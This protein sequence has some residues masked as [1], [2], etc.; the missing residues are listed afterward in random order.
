VIWKKNA[1]DVWSFD[2]VD[3]RNCFFRTIKGDGLDKGKTRLLFELVVYVR[4]RNND[5]VT[6]MC[7]GWCELP[8]ADL[9]NSM[10]HKLEIQGGSPK[11]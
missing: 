11:A 1:V 8:F 2:T 4:G 3:L 10:P 6:E 5:K 9:K 7:C